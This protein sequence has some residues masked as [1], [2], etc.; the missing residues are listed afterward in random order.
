MVPDEK[1]AFLREALTCTATQTIQ[2]FYVPLGYRQQA[3]S[4]HQLEIFG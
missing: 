4:V 2:L 1:G 3:H